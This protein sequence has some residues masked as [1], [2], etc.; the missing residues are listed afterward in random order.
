MRIK[1]MKTLHRNFHSTEKLNHIANLK[2]RLS[3]S[4]AHGL[5]NYFPMEAEN[6]S[7]PPISEASQTKVPIKEVHQVLNQSIEI[8]SKEKNIVEVPRAK[9]VTVVGDTHGQFYDLLNLLEQ[10]LPPSKDNLFVFNGDF[11]DRG[12]FSFQTV[13]LLLSYKVLF[14]DQIFLLRGNHE[15]IFMNRMYGFLHEILAKYD[16]SVLRRFWDVFDSLPFGAI[17]STDTKNFGTKK[18]LVLH[19]GLAKEKDITIKRLQ[20]IPRQKFNAYEQSMTM[21]NAEHFTKEEVRLL[22][23]YHDILWSDPQLRNGLAK[24][25]ARG[26]GLL[27]G[28][29]VTKSFLEKNGLDMIVRSHQVRRNGYTL[30]HEKYLATVFSAP[31]YCDGVRNK[32]AVIKF[33]DF[34]TDWR[35]FETFEAVPHPPIPPMIHRELYA[36]KL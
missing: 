8:L 12:A 26:G 5:R 35:R 24:N 29:D 16:Q 33:G 7:F 3:N 2:Q 25:R 17:V 9:T 20:Q 27:F 28:P 15:T 13:F 23:V 18:A 21:S 6:G 31:R 1:L 34:G 10:N 4:W 22:K 32:G 11:V 30:E 14:P 19:G 36:A